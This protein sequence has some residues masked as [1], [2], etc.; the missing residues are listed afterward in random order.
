MAKTV[1]LDCQRLNRPFASFKAANSTSLP[2]GTRSADDTRGSMAEANDPGPRMSS[3]ASVVNSKRARPGSKV[4]RVIPAFAALA[5]LFAGY[6][7]ALFTSLAS[8]ELTT[9]VGGRAID[10]GAW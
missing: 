5:L 6:S 1:S 9:N 10:G 3:N 2:D 8:S 4:R 7:A